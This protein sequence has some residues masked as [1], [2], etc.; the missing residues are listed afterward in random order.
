MQFFTV[1][2]A[3]SLGNYFPGMPLKQGKQIISNENNMIKY[4]NWKE[5]DQLAI[6]KT[7]RI[8]GHRRQIHLAAGRE[9]ESNRDLRIGSPAP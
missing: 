1:V 8:R 7:F 4:P 2:N 6:Y 9:E 5:A 3:L